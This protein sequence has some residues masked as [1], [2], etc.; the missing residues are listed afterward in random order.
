MSNSPLAVKFTGVLSNVNWPPLGVNVTDFAPEHFSKEEPI[1]S[2]G[3]SGYEKFNV[4]ESL[5]IG[6]AELSIM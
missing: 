6:V 4:T 5:F 2:E 3:L 1:E